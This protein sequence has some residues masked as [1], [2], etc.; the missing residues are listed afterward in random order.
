M[1]QEGG[2]LYK[3]SHGKRFGYSTI[4]GRAGEHEQAY[5]TRLWIGRLRLHIFYRGDNDPDCHDHP[6]DFWT[7][8]LTPYIEEVLTP[9]RDTSAEGTKPKPQRYQRT[10]QV[11]PAWR[12][13]FRPA[14]HTH[15][16]LGP[17]GDEL[18]QL[19]AT[20]YKLPQPS[21]GTGKIITLVWRAKAERPWG[22]LK[23]RGGKWCWVGWKDY[24]FGGGK[25]A[26]CS[27]E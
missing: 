10:R 14:T 25:D 3:P 13:S 6:W 21:I 4:Y 24:V 9:I 23:D 17:V 7:F 12:W 15:R 1:G 20:L 18:D 22:F 5:I 11:V 19:V 2:A 16:V 8:P 27:D 26:P